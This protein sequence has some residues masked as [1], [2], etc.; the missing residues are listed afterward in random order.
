MKA[1]RAVDALLA[2]LDACDE[3]TCA[4]SLATDA[5]ARQIAKRLTL[6]D[7]LVERIATA[8]L[9]HDIGKI[10]TPPSILLKPG[11]LDDAEWAVMREHAAAGAAMVAAIPALAAY[12]PIV[13]SHHERIDGNGYP[14]GLAGDAIL[15]EARVVAVADAFHSMVSDR[16]YRRAR[17]AGEAMEILRAGRGSQWDALVVDVMIDVVATRRTRAV[18]AE[19]TSMLGRAG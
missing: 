15:F 2:T 10:A 19:L 18:D 12:A 17:L 5:W 9:L 16:P 11:P 3:A 13:R 1:A 14:D 6:P 7:D 8:G 4:H